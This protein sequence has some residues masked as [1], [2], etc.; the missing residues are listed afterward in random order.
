MSSL[1]QFSMTV[2]LAF[3]ELRKDPPSYSDLTFD[4]MQR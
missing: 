2:R 4:V 1:F 3:Q